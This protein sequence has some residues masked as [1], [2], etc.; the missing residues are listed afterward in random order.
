[1]QVNNQP[2]VPRGQI[3]RLFF[4]CVIY[5]TEEIAR[6]FALPRWL[7][8]MRIAFVWSF[9]WLSPAIRDRIGFR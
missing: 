2:K 6:L 1:M 4:S 3:N 7:R 9:D 5:S 8:Y